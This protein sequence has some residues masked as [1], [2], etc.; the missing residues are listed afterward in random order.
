MPEDK[1]NK[2]AIDE[3][4]GGLNKSP[5][6]PFESKDPFAVEAEETEDKGEEKVE[7]KPLA[8]HRDPKVLKFIE[9]EVE[10][11]T[12]DLKPTDAPKAVDSEDEFTEVL[13]RVIGNDTPEKVQAVKDMRKVF[14]SL[15]ER[16]AQKAL[17]QIQAQAQQRIEEDKAA[18]EELES[19]FE[20]I[21]ESYGVDLTSNTPAARKLDTE[22]RNYIRK[23]AP[24][25]ADGDVAAFPDLTAAFETFQELQKRPS[26]NRAKELASRGMSRSNDASSAPVNTD[27]SWKG[28]EKLFNKLT[29]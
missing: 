8:F 11:R 4:L 29:G 22:F 3:F 17:A 25:N 9:K 10:K 18:Q 6:N 19:S 26:N 12:R 7:E 2:S 15:E 1:T 24:K 16:G 5:E 28:V 20:D 21:E 23:I 13:T 14:G 27:K